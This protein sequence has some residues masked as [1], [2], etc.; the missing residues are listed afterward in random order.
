MEKLLRLGSL[1]EPSGPA[2]VSCPSAPDEGDWMAP[3]IGD[4]GPL[5]ADS[6]SSQDMERLSFQDEPMPLLFQ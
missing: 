2:L 5:A 4:Q 1:A 6:A 3:R